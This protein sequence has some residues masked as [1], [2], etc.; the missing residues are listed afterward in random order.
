[1]TEKLPEDFWTVEVPID[2][3][4]MSPDVGADLTKIDAHTSELESIVRQ[5]WE[6]M[7]TE[8]KL[9]E[10][11]DIPEPEEIL[12]PRISEEEFRAAIASLNERDE[13]LTGQAENEQPSTE[14]QKR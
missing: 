5:M 3:F 9:L 8:T 12:I 13:S 4:A 14:D 11:V 10:G 1:M 2:P 6:D 7:T